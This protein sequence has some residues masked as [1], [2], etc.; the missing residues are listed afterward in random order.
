ALI[1][2]L[3]KNET[4]LD[5][6]RKYPA[7]DRAKLVSDIAHGLHFLHDSNV[8]HGD[9]KPNNI[10]IDDDGNALVADFGW[11]TVL[12]YKDHL[13]KHFVESVEYMAPELY[14][15]AVGD[16]AGVEERGASFSKFTKE[17]DVYAFAIVAFRVSRVY[18]KVLACHRANRIVNLGIN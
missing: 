5:Y 9:M 15:D 12:E 4:V 1:S 13:A 7:V 11:S 17:A 8:V 10:L 6:L 14:D 2:P 18:Y 3:W 16:S